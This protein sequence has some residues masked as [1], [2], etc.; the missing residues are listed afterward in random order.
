MMQSSS[1][2][3]EALENSSVYF[4]DINIRDNIPACIN[5]QQ[6]EQYFLSNPIIDTL[7]G[8]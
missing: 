5:Y 8:D 2:I 6:I 3:N 7:L 4:I 1:L